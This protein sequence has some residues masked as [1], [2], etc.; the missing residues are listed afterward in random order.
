MTYTCHAA[1]NV[2]ITRHAA[3]NDMYVSNNGDVTSNSFLGR[4]VQ[5]EQK[6]RE[7]D[8]YI[9]PKGEN[10]MAACGFGCKNPLVGSLHKQSSDSLFRVTS[11]GLHTVF[12]CDLLARAG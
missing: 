11:Q 3:L 12:T 5:C 1:L 10:S 9:H 4:L 6:G 8:R 2:Y 7:V